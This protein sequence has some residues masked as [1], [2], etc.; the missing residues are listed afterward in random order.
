MTKIVNLNVAMTC[1]GCA[2]A[3]TRILNK[4]EGIIINCFFIIYHQILFMLLKL[5]F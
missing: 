3:V 1:G 5:F 2:G 4:I